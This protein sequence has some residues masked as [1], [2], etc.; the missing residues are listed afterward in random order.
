[1]KRSILV[2]VIAIS[3]FA[4]SNISY[5]FAMD[6]TVMNGTHM[7]NISNDT[8][9]SISNRSISGTIE[10]SKD[11]NFK[12][13]VNKYNIFSEIEAPPPTTVED[14]EEFEP[15]LLNK[16][17]IDALKE[18]IQTGESATMEGATGEDNTTSIDPSNITSIDFC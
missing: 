11:I 15:N 14:L 18:E 3:T 1:M 6:D 12:E 2:L 16:E 5:T 9:P 17:N 8:N 7:T 13:A 4:V 10:G